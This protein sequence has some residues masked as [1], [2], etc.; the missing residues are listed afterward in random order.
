MRWAENIARMEMKYFVKYLLESLKARKKH[1]GDRR[2][3]DGNIKRNL[4]AMGYGGVD[5]TYMALARDRSLVIVN[6][7]MNLRVP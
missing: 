1:S 3:W 6:R 5:L 4:R 7:V 2:N